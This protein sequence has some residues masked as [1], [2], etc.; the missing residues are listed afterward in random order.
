MLNQVQG[1]NS[2]TKIGTKEIF[3]GIFVFKLI[4]TNDLSTLQWVYFYKY[5][6]IYTFI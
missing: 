1:E 2:E 6:S 3:F 4:Y 5:Y